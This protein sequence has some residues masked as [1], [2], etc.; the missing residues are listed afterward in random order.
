MTMTDQVTGEGRQVVVAAQAQARRL[1]QGFIG[2]E[3]LLYGLACADG[4]VGTL[5]R[6]RGAT[7]ERCEA[8]FV[9]LVSSGRGFEADAIDGEALSSLGINLDTVR[10]R[11]DA[12]FGPGA[13]TGA[14][15]RPHRR[16]RPRSRTTTGHLPL[17]R[18]ARACLDRSMRR[19]RAAEPGTPQKLE[20][21]HIALE[22]FAMNPDI[23]NRVLTAMGISVPA[24]RSEILEHGRPAG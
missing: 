20:A 14:E 18:Q 2:C 3:H 5:L 23:P 11:V 15:T 16:R 9:R 8:E 12:V 13:L 19:A 7:P 21:E 1:G 6:E 17:T 10:E 22:L 24:L 4:D